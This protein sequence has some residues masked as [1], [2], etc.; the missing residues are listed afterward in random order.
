MRSQRMGAMFSVQ[1]VARRGFRLILTIARQN[2]HPNPR[3]RLSAYLN[4]R[5][6]R[7][8]ANLSQSP[9]QVK[10][11]WLKMSVLKRP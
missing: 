11:P 5:P 6:S 7:R 1:V 4:Q 2:L 9:R 8:A 3:Q 10:R